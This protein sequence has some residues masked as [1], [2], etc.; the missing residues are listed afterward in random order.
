[1]QT[2]VPVAKRTGRGSRLYGIS[3]DY[4]ATAPPRSTTRGP[5]PRR[6]G[7]ASSRPQ[8]R[9]RRPPPRR[10]KGMPSISRSAPA[11]PAGP[12]SDRT[13]V[14]AEV[15]RAS[16]MGDTRSAG[17]D[18][19]HVPA[20]DVAWTGGSVGRGT[21]END[22]G[23]FA[24]A[25]AGSGGRGFPDRRRRHLRH[26]RRD[27]G[28]HA[29]AQGRGGRRGRRREHRGRRRPCELRRDSRRGLYRARSGRRRQDGRR[30]EGRPASTTRPGASRSPPTVGPAPCP[31]P[32]A[33][34]RF[35]PTP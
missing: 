20:I 35:W 22:Q 26:R 10:V 30:A 2:A 32:T 7:R 3:M 17:S 33:S 27:P 14:Y 24:A 19:N 12:I 34:S 25:S 21:A 6:W 31:P 16:A 11:S 28:P 9:R 13:G 18:G 8:Q 23:R 1:M 5:S 15:S 29:R 4:K